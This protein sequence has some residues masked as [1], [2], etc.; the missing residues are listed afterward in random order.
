V[1]SIQS[2]M[3]VCLGFFIALLLGLIIA[4]AFWTRAVRLTTQ[5]LKAALPIN[6]SE[7]R[8]DKDRLRAEY[9]VKVHQ[10]E[11]HVEQAKLSA[12]RQMIELN[13]RDAA[14][15][16]LE[17]R[18]SEVKSSLEEN[19]NARR[20][21]EQTITDRLPKIEA[22]LAEAKQLLSTRDR[23][24]A[25][26]NADAQK[27]RQSLDE[28]SAVI[29]QLQNEKRRLQTN[30]ATAEARKHGQL[31]DPHFEAEVAMR[32]EVEALRARARDQSSVIDRLQGKPARPGGHTANGGARQSA[33][34][35]GDGDA[36]ATTATAERLQ[37]DLAAAELALAQAKDAAMARDALEKQ[38][39]S[40]TGQIEDQAAE[41][42]RLRAEMSA[43]VD[44]AKED[45]RLSIKDS[46]LGL[47]A[48]LGGLSAKSDQQTETIQRLRSEL[49][50]SNERSARQA[51][52]FMDQ[53][54]RLGAGTAT[55]S[56]PRTRTGT[57][58]GG[59][60]SAGERL[61]PV[62][63]GM[64]AR[65]S[66]TGRGADE[67]NGSVAAMAGP[68]LVAIS[69]TARPSV[70]PAQVERV[71][72]FLK[73][74]GEGILPDNAVPPLAPAGSKA[75]SSRSGA[76]P[77]NGAAGHGTAA[78]SD[79]AAAEAA[80]VRADGPAGPSP[81]TATPAASGA[82]SSPGPSKSDTS[83]RGRLLDRLTGLDKN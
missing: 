48:K 49:A 32:S 75:G 34:P 65:S 31:R 43:M 78:A 36:M 4:P 24:I 18:M 37:R 71:N 8:A 33:T 7:I 67:Q 5:R 53:M 20:V 22:R 70:N 66:R 47:K 56:E 46:K 44:G 6:E 38:A 50:A 2:V 76:A 79:T 54:R 26:L 27:Q 81:A 68:P 52:Y 58:G 82:G 42:A 13:R 41:I 83:R 17:T 10:L 45:R 74:L 12:A 11:T 59:R 40:L 80:V 35:S 62:R 19:Q 39:K 69:T 21:L 3:L 15:G 72:G 60:R 55:H 63:A 51:T 57:P 16:L 73:A 23:E 9:A 25:G 14:I 1:I 61:A 64:S 30:L 29:A 77:Q 28:A